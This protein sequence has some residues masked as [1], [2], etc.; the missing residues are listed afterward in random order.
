MSV[1][2]G[3]KIIQAG[4]LLVGLLLWSGPVHAATDDLAGKALTLDECV[5]IGLQTN[6]A[7]EISAQNRLAAREKVAEAKGGYYPTFKASS[8]YTYTTPAD[9]K[10]GAFP[11]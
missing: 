5:A 11:R 4:L 6:P 1:G 9:E 8:A 7:V 3:V 2:S 10:M